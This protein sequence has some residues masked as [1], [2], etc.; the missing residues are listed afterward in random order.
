MMENGGNNGCSTFL[1]PKSQ[2]MIRL[3]FSLSADSHSPPFRFLR[4][5]SY[6]SLS[7]VYFGESWFLASAARVAGRDVF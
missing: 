5:F 1:A 3:R 4:L 7:F 2:R 6:F